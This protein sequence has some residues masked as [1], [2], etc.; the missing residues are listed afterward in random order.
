MLAGI[1]EDPA[2]YAPHVF[3]LWTKPRKKKK[4][5]IIMRRQKKKKN[6]KNK[7]YIYIYIYIFS[8]TPFRAVSVSGTFPFR[9]PGTETAFRVTMVGEDRTS[10]LR[11]SFTHRFKLVVDAGS[12]FINALCAHL[13]VCLPCQSP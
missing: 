10:I 4:K 1:V 2:R 5:K 13:V 3:D 6:K 7:I 8:E 9:F 12:L 11:P